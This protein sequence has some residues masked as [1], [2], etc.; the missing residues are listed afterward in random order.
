MMRVFG[1][2]SHTQLRPSAEF[3]LVS[4]LSGYF[5]SHIWNTFLACYG[6]LPDLQHGWLGYSTTYLTIQGEM[7]ERTILTIRIIS[8]GTLYHNILQEFS[9]ITQPGKTAEMVPYRTKYHI[10]L[11]AL[12]LRQLAVDK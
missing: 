9:E 5:K 12:R 10:L 1:S 6:L 11:I 2:Q 4:Y 3:S 7:A 8:T